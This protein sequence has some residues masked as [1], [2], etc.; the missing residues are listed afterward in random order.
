MKSFSA[1]CLKNYKKAVKSRMQIF[2]AGN[3]TETILAFGKEYL[4]SIFDHS[5]SF[6]C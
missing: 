2:K 6:P 3:K 5:S 4:G 1:M